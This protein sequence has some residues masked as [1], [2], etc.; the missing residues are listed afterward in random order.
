MIV[1]RVLVEVKLTSLYSRF[2]R[3]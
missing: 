2:S 1:I 3:F